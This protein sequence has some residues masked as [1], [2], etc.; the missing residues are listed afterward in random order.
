[1]QNILFTLIILDHIIAKAPKLHYGGRSTRLYDKT[2]GVA[3]N[4]KKVTP[5][6]SSFTS[7][8]QNLTTP[9]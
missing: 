4:N 1:M 6:G 5:M 2:R 8:S 7:A 9:N 3:T